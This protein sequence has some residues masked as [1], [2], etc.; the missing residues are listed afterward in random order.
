MKH[1]FFVLV[2]VF[3]V[4]L[5][6]SLF[7]VSTSYALVCNT[8]NPNDVSRN[9]TVSLSCGNGIVH[10]SQGCSTPMGCSAPQV[11]ACPVSATPPISGGTTSGGSTSGAGTSYNTGTTASTNTSLPAPCLVQLGSQTCS[12]TVSNLSSSGTP[13]SSAHSALRVLID[14][15][16]PNS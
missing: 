10:T 1:N 16:G 4:T 2:S 12:V 7:F 13:N 3:F 14:A 6:L 15:V 8:I 5:F 11:E 9:C